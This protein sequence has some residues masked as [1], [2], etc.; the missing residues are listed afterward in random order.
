MAAEATAAPATQAAISFADGPAAADPAMAALDA[1]LSGEGGEAAPA[2][3]ETAAEAKPAGE[4]AAAAPAATEPKAEAKTEPPSNDVEAARL[5]K[6]FSKLAER[7]QKL[8]ERENAARDALAQAQG[9][10]EK[11]DRFAEFEKDPVAFF[12][13]NPDAEQL[14][15]LLAGITALE[16][17][18]AERR[19]D[20]IEARQKRER[21]QSERDTQVKKAQEWRE[22]IAKNIRDAG[23]RFDLVNSLGLH[24]DVINVMT[25]Y[26]EKHSKRD[27]KGNVIEPAILPWETA[28]EA[29]ENTRAEW[30]DKNSKRYGKRTPAAAAPATPAPSKEANASDGTKPAPKR[31][32]NPTLSNVPV[33]EAPVTP[34]QLSL[35]PAERERQV[36][37]ELGL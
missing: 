5:R 10:R 36:L 35:D 15:K 7:E 26:Y 22:G 24:G 3:G 33:A 20:E 12:L 21:E 14:N 16:K 17:S 9:L 25:A 19:L 27:E 2:G 4:P 8:L 31:T 18:P 37:A 1:V 29:V 28:A 6:G 34:G 13:A 11:A 30:L 32:G 23:E